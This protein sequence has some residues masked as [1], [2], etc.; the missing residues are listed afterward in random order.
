MQFRKFWATRI[1]VT[2]LMAAFLMISNAGFAMAD[3]KDRMVER[4][5]IEAAV[6]GMPT[7]GMDEI[8]RLRIRLSA[9]FLSLRDWTRKSSTSPSQ[10]TA[11][12]RYIRD[13]VG[14]VV[15]HRQLPN[16]NWR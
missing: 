15:E 13:G 10:S 14:R 8:T 3:V 1:L 7:N 16:S 5:A 6:W 4:R 2:G 12:H 11:R 9:A